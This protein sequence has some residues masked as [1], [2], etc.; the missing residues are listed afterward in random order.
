MQVCEMT[1]EQR[2]VYFFDNSQKKAVLAATEKFIT[3][4][5][6]GSN[7]DCYERLHFHNK[8]DANKNVDVVYSSTYEVKKLVEEIQQIK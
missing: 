4:E 3:I 8:K 1:D 2:A 5:T 7:C 6:Y